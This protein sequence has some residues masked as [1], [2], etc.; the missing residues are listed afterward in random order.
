MLLVDSILTD[1]PQN[2]GDKQGRST[3]DSVNLAIQWREVNPGSMSLP[4][5]HFSPI[6]LTF[7]SV[8]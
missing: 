1:N 4:S 5:R 3:F 8:P 2:Y 7:Y 6:F